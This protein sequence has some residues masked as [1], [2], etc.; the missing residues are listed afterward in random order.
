MTIAGSELQFQEYPMILEISGRN[1]VED[2][3]SASNELP[4]PGF[5]SLNDIKSLRP[6]LS[7]DAEKNTGEYSIY[8]K[9]I[10]PSITLSTQKSKY[11]FNKEHYGSHCLSYGYITNQTERE[12]T[13]YTQGDIQ[14]C[15]KWGVFSRIIKTVSCCLL[16]PVMTLHAM[17]ICMRGLGCMCGACCVNDKVLNKSPID[18][19][20]GIKT[21][22]EYCANSC[23]SYGHATLLCAECW[24][25]IFCC[26]VEICV[27]ECT[28]KAGLPQIYRNYEKAKFSI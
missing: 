4:N 22:K 20:E 24:T 2:F 8:I 28:Y 3:Y 21:D 23:T 6:K 26:P 16:T 19:V 15:V 7:K 10:E 17:G 14:N 18:K 13:A 25:N 9:D 12:I 27:P 1:S 5:D 11:T